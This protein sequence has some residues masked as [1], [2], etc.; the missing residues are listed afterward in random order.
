MFYFFPLFLGIMNA[1]RFR[2]IV[3][4]MSTAMLGLIAMQAYWLKHDFELKAQQFDQT[5]MQA[6]NRMVEQIEESENLRIVVKNFISTGDSAIT[7]EVMSDSLMQVLEGIASSS[8]P[9]PPMSGNLLQMRKEINARIDSFRDKGDFRLHNGE[10]KILQVDSSLDIRIE[11]N[12]L[13]KEV[14]DLKVAETPE[15]PDSPLWVNEKRMQ[16]RLQK[17]NTIMQKLTFQIVDPR[18]NIF[19]RISQRSLD[20]IISI[21][22]KNSE[23]NDNYSYGIISKDQNRLIY[24]SQH[25]D[26]SAIL[27][28]PFKLTL[29]P[30]DVFKKNEML[31]LEIKDKTGILLN[32]FFPVLLLS[33]IFTGCIIWGFTY[34]LGVILRQKK[35]AAIKNDFINNMTHEFKTPIATI[36][37]ANESINDPRVYQSPE[38]MKFYTGIIRDENN[39]MLRQVETV[40]QMAQL[41]KGELNFNMEEVKLDDLIESAI[42]SMQLTIEQRGGH[43]GYNCNTSEIMVKADPNHLTN[44]IINLLDNAIKYSPVNPDISVDIYSQSHKIYVSISDKGIGMTREVQQRIFDTFF[45]ASGGNIHDVKGFGLGLSYVKAIIEK[46]HG[47]VLVKSEPGKGSTFTLILPL[48]KSNPA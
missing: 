44:V 34:T 30:N 7:E 9:A 3:I 11:K 46:H 21:E 8:S 27:N 10:S 42:A 14:I 20:S 25:P 43:I 19:E 35:L 45:R 37:I 33:I 17:L 24:S 32:N 36:A 48:L 16:T 31:S 22:M 29:F 39:R 28:S 40:L 13:Q 47:E 41:D 1:I 26:T 5:V 23:L 38:K 4:T 15:L 6:L 12:I 2:F 18:G